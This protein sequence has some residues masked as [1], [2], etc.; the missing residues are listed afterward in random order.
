MPC[1]GANGIYRRNWFNMS[2][3]NATTS[4]LGYWSYAS[5]VY[6]DPTC[7][8]T[9]VFN[10]SVSGLFVV[11]QTAMNRGP[12]A[13]DIT[14]FN[15]TNY[16]NPIDVTVITLQY[17]F[18]YLGA[19]IANESQ[20]FNLDPNRRP[21]NWAG[22]FVPT[23]VIGTLQSST[24]PESINGIWGG[25]CVYNMPCVSHGLPVVLQSSPLSHTRTLF[26]VRFLSSLAHA[27]RPHAR[28][29]FLPTGAHS[30]CDAS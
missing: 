10:I 30:T 13:A 20:N 5:F 1:H 27:T 15:G 22:P 2:A 9:A 17:P 28:A 12:G 4:S 25:D 3:V 24:T 6:T 23:A 8:T 21:L 11:E 14:F 26:T 7:N 18:L 16:N 19:N 29:L